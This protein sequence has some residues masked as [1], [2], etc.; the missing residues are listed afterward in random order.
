MTLTPKSY[1]SQFRSS[2]TIRL[3]G[4]INVSNTDLIRYSLTY[5]LLRRRKCSSTGFIIKSS[6]TYFVL[7]RSIIIKMT[8]VQPNED[9][10][11]FVRKE[12]NEDLKM[13]LV[14]PNEDMQAFVR[15]ELNEDLNTRDSDLQTIKEWLA[16][17]PHLPDT[18]DDSRIMTFLRGCKFSL[19]KCK[20]KLD[21]YFTMRTACPE[22]FNNRDIDRHELAEIMDCVTIPPLPGLTPD[23]KRVI[24][25]RGK[26][27][28]Q[29]PIVNVYDAMKIALMVGD[30]RLAAEETGVAGDVYIL[31]AS[32][33][34]PAYFA[35]FTPGAVKKFLLI[36]QEAYPVKLKEVHVVNISPLVHTIIEWVK[37][38]LKEKIK[39]RIHV[40]TDMESLYKFVP[41]DVLPEEYGGTAGKAEEYGGTAGK[42]Q[43]FHD[44]WRQKLRDYKPWFQEQENVKADENYK[45]WFQEQ[46]NVKA[47]ESKRPGQPTN[48]D[49]LFGVDGSFRI[50]VHTDMES[51]YKF[52]PKDVLPEEYGGTAGKVQAFHDQWR[53]KL[54]DYKPWFQEQE[55]VKADESKRPGQ[56]TRL[57]TMVPRAGK[58]ES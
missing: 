16:K 8:L 58:R 15:K 11:A 51:L 22:L 54:R 56:P 35:K 24:V 39:N 26:T 9:M 2:S 21:M 53:Q 46:E 47:D 25:L 38:F 32:I 36:V 18:W 6:R 34:S 28:K 31:D 44:Q 45:P 42:V 41:K 43:A 52:V 30:I 55:N 20:R 37:P 33:V 12:L 4:D 17:Q 5:I 49:D 14:Q 10:Q 48:Y 23:A 50:H 13:T 3:T 1:L 57:Q 19:E 27:E 40:H 29:I 7:N